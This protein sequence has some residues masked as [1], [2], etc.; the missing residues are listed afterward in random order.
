MERL[1]PLGFPN[2]LFIEQL[3]TARAQR[4]NDPLAMRKVKPEEF[5]IEQIKLVFFVTEEITKPPIV[6]QNAAFLVDN[7][8]CC[9]TVVEDLTKL[10][11]LLQNLMFVPSQSGDVID[12]EHALAAYKTNMASAIRDLRIGQEESEELAGLGSP[13]HFLIEDLTAVHAKRLDD[14]RTP[15]KIMPELTRVEISKPLLLITE[16]LP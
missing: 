6:E 7:T 3:A 11:L 16:H 2:H 9:R 13:C 14:Y 8:D 10:A 15:F 5:R 12:P 1:I 4:I